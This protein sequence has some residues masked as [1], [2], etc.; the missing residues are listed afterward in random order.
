MGRLVLIKSVLSV[1]PIFQCFAMLAPIGIMNQIGL[2]IIKI[3][4]Q[5]GKSITK[6]YH[7]INWK[8][9]KVPKDRGGLGVKD[10]SLMNMA[11]GT[12]LL[13][14]MTTGRLE[15]WKKI[16]WK[17]YFK[18]ARN[19]CLENLVEPQKGSHIWKLLKSI[20][21]LLCSRIT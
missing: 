12:K 4:W 8:I 10:L 9:V 5:G 13:W 19:R 18:G 17:K 21:P 15:R 16:L 14:R 3:L 11:M 1:L 2:N 6:N 20:D 7:L